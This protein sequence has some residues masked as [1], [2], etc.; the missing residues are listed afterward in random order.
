MYADWNSLLLRFEDA[1]FI[2][3][4]SG[5]MPDTSGGYQ[6]IQTL[7]TESLHSGLFSSRVFSLTGIIIAS[8][9]FLLMIGSIIILKRK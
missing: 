1:A 4:M 6:Q 2:P 8:G 7:N 9:L 3:P 5:V